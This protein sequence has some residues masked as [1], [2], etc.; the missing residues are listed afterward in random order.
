MNY[1]PDAT[2][3]PYRWK[4]TNFGREQERML[5]NDPYSPAALSGAGSE[6]E[7]VVEV[8]TDGEESKSAMNGSH[9][10]I[11]PAPMNV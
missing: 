4:H 10:S 2:T 3:Q 7:E 6:V 1:G 9:Q 5:S 11:L 8:D